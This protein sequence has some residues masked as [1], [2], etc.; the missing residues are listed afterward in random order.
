MT[1]LIETNAQ[2]TTSIKYLHPVQN[3]ISGYKKT[4]KIQCKFLIFLFLLTVRS[5]N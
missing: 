1:A 4:K 5:L 3:V 2:V